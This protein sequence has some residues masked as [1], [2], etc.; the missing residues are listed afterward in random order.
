MPDWTSE[1]ERRLDRF[2]LP[3]LEQTRIIQEL[4]DHLD[5]RVAE[6]CR[7]GTS[8]SE[9]TRLAL[10][11]ISDDEL[12]RG[13]WRA[14]P[15]PIAAE[16]PPE[17]PAARWL[18]GLL[19]D[20]RYGARSL[21]RQRGF[22]VAATLALG[23]GIGGTTAIIAA[24]DA[25]LLRPMPFPHAD[26]LFVPAGQ[27]LARSMPRVTVTF[28]DAEDWRREDASV[29]PRRGVA[30][31]RGG[32]HRGWRAR[33]RPD[34]H[35]ERRVLLAHRR[36]AGRGPHAHPGR[37]WA[38]RAPGHRDWSCALAAALRRRTRRRRAARYAR[39]G[40]ARDRRCPSGPSGL[41]RGDGAVCPD[42]HR[43]LRPRRPY[44]ARQHDLQ[45]A[46][47]PSRRR[48]AE[49]AQ[50][51][52]HGDGR[53]HRA[54][55]PKERQDWTIAL[56]PLRDYIVQPET[57]RALYILLAAVAG[58]LLIACANV[59]N[60]A[61]VRGS[62]RA[63]ELAVRVSL[64][65]SRQRLIQQLAVEGAVLASAGAVLGV[66]LATLIMQGAG[67]HGPAS[68]A[69]LGRR[70]VEWPRAARDRARLRPGRDPLR[71][72]FRP[73]RSPPCA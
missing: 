37:P 64:G 31:R 19:R 47:T 7:S 3:P 11:E 63:R 66:G 32:S 35:R 28:A 8:V 57:S 71:A 48:L 38:R 44:A 22:T 60:L 53:P 68:D 51:R 20:V 69:L 5:D 65:A 25:V 50:S 42:E 21:M 15:L 6:L 72:S 24:V 33:A 52:L 36:R 49:Q 73:S 41:A 4:S 67:G 56:V 12:R 10:D 18:E 70:P 30:A 58:V 46:G 27:N 13:G 55:F 17:V 16:P 39:R 34:G 9:A 14:L 23:L 2:D 43:R 59:A 61:L 29:Q 45:R 54:G 62:G 26:R 1:L 40:A